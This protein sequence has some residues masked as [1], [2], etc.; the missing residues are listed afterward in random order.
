MSARK[1]DR[2]KPHPAND[3]IYGDKPDRKLI[4]SIKDNGILNPLLIA[5]DGR[6]I[7][8][9]RRFVGAQQVGLIE[10]PVVVFASKDEDVI[11]AALI[12]SNRQ[13]KKTKAMIAKE[14][15]ELAAIE[16]RSAEARQEA[17][18]FKTRNEEVGLLGASVEDVIVAHQAEIEETVLL[19]VV[20]PVHTH[21]EVAEKLGVSPATAQNA[22]VVGEELKRLESS[23]KLEDQERAG[24][25]LVMVNE[26]GFKPAAATVMKPSVNGR[27]RGLTMVEST[28]SAIR[29]TFN[30][31]ND[32]VS[33]AKWTW[34]PVTGCLHD[35]PYCYARDIAERFYPQG[36]APT[37]H[38]DRLAAPRNTRLPKVEGWERRVFTCSMAD[39]FGKV[40]PRDWI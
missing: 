25:L 15:A 14:A 8:G 19:P 34:N 33:W 10:V 6:I 9:H 11:L 1:I 17:A 27:G 2:L 28:P 36:F 38:E 21:V 30:Q 7:S 5:W 39:L 12:E 20:K 37:F 16:R 24:E 23:E 18:Q 32:K 35:C 26:R 40:V 4:E 22:I 3:S 29:A 31:T 13:R